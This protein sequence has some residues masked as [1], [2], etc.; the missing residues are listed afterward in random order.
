MV[1][2]VCASPGQGQELD[3][4]AKKKCMMIMVKITEIDDEG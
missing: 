2:D 4:K 1:S 3:R